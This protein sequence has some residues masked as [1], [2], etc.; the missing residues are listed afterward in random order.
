MYIY[1]YV[2][3]CIYYLQ[4]TFTVNYIRIMG[5]RD[6]FTINNKVLMD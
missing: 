3:V 6:T 4:C 1:I 5:L 2:C